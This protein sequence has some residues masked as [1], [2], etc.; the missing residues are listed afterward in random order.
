MAGT[1]EV[2]GRLYGPTDVLGGG[3]V[4]AEGEAGRSGL[5]LDDSCMLAALTIRRLEKS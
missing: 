1:L 3:D 5:G 2:G 4:C